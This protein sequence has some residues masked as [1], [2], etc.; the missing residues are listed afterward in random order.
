[1]LLWGRQ[2][3]ASKHGA[4]NMDPGVVVV[5]VVVNGWMWMGER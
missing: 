1:M 3:E 2:A 5:V 4:G